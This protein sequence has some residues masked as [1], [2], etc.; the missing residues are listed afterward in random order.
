MADARWGPKLQGSVFRVMC[1]CG[2]IARRG[3]RPWAGRPTA[4]PSSDL[5]G[6][7]AGAREHDPDAHQQTRYGGQAGSS[8]RTV[9]GAAPRMTVSMFR[10]EDRKSVVWGR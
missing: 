4:V 9:A 3:E 2:R 6:P 10:G 7:A 5:E 1:R 8:S